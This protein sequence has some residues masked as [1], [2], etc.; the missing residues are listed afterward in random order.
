MNPRPHA[1]ITDADFPSLAEEHRVFDAAGVEVTVATLPDRRRRDR[2][3]TRGRRP[4]RPLG[5]HHPGGAGR[6]CPAARSSSATAS[7][8]TTSTWQRR[9]DHGIRISNIPDYASGEVA[10]HTLALALALARQLSPI[11]RR[12][13]GGQW[14]IVPEGP[15]PSFREMR[16]V[17]LGYGRI[18][19]EVAARA[20][21]FGFQIATHDPFVSD[22]D[23]RAAGRR[24]AGPRQG[25]PERRH[26]QPPPAAHGGDP[27]P[28][29]CR[30]ALPDEAHGLGRKY[31]ARRPGRHRRP[32]AG[33]VPERPARS[34]AGRFRT[35]AAAGR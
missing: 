31:L 10:D 17:T 27:A 2:G 22:A 34:R 29:E 32:R 13:R 5:A 21:A 24:A 35:G 7:G 14:K 23:L 8:S 18:A 4:A 19:R 9:R 15:M 6:R 20:R 33:V 11:D 26:P 3:R 28:P 30:P 12:L 1:L 25:D 16:F